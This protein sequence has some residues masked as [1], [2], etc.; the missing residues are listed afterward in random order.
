[1]NIYPREIENALYLNEAVADCAVFGVP[2]DKWGESLVAVVQTASGASLSA[3]E[4]VAWCREHLA[5]YKRP[6]RGSSSTS[7]RATPTARSSSASSA[8]QYL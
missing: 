2:D 7:S 5:D 6:R 3:D 1:M 4:V 8:A